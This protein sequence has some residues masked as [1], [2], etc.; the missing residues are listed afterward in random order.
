VE[1]RWLVFYLSCNLYCGCRASSPAE[2][3]KEKKSG[4]G[5]GEVKIGDGGKS[6]CL[7]INA[8]VMFVYMNEDSGDWYIIAKH[9]SKTQ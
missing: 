1:A 8:E 5:L 2:C 4:A 7:D 9:S 6:L 3:S